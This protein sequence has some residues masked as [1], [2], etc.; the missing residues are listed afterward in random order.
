[1]QAEPNEAGGQAAAADTTG[2]TAAA[3]QGDGGQSANQDQTTGTGSQATTGKGS[4]TGITETFFDPKSIEHDPNLMAAYKQMQG[5]FTKKSQSI[6]EQQ[7]KIEAYDAFTQN[8]Q[9]YL[10]QLATQ[11]GYNLVQHDSNGQDTTDEAPK[12]WADVYS[13]AKEEVLQELQPYLGQIQKL[14]QDNMEQYLDTTYKDWRT[15]EDDMLGLLKEHPTLANN[16]D[17]LYNMAV[18][19]EV[20]EARMLKAAQAKLKAGTDGGNVSG[21]G[22]PSQQTKSRYEGV[23]DFNSAVAAAKA[24]LARKGIKPPGA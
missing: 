3:P 5:A 2:A 16:P 22:A 18:P 23:T 11:H 21:A 13:K 19:T 8:P 10:Q 12:T 7:N 24:E 15:Y 9:E 14:R 20:R 17:M 1:M 6:R 4:E